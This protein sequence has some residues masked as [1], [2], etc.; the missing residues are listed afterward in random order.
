MGEVAM[1]G[2][3]GYSAAAYH[4]RFMAFLVIGHSLFA[5]LFGWFGGCLAKRLYRT[6]GADTAE[7]GDV[8]TAAIGD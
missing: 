5:L 1:L 2:Q 6:N 7:V 8:K 3:G 4:A